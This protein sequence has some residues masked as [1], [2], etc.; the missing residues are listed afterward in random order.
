MFSN[1]KLYEDGRQKPGEPAGFMVGERILCLFWHN[2][3]QFNDSDMKVQSMERSIAKRQSW[4]VMSLLRKA[5]VIYIDHDH[6]HR[7]AK[8]E[9]AATT[10]LRTK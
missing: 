7:V 2:H 1:C 4:Y 8:A 6:L 5:E 10:V 9:T 3:E